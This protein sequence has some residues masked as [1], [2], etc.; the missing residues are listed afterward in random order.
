MKIESLIFRRLLLVKRNPDK[1]ELEKWLNKLIP[2]N[3]IVKKIYK[4][5]KI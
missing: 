2:K 4:N 1:E 3:K 5:G